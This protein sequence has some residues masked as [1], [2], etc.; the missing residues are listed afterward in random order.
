MRGNEDFAGNPRL[1]IEKNPAEHE[2]TKP[3]VPFFLIQPQKNE[4]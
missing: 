3:P 1:K 4:F 2:A